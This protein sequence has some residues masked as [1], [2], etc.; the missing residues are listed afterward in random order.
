[1]LPS[2]ALQIATCNVVCGATLVVQQLAVMHLFRFSGCLPPSG[3]KLGEGG[4][5]LC[6]G[7][8]GSLVFCSLPMGIAVWGGMLT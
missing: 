2:S 1:M 3:C 4:S 7:W 5:A 6:H 8:T